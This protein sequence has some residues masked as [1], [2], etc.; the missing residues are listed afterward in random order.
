[1]DVQPGTRHSHSSLKTL[2]R[3][4]RVYTL[5]HPAVGE[6]VL[7]DNR[8][9]ERIGTGDPPESDRIVELPGA[10]IIPGFIDTHVHLTGTTLSEIG[11]PL[12][13]ARSG[14]ELLGLTVDYNDPATTK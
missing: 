10:T 6:C 8:H 14:E 2:Y 9:I 7:V 13:R 3:A 1:M 5:S 12:G 11:I 4:T